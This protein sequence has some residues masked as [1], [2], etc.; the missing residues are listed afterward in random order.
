MMPNSKVTTL[1]ACLAFGSICVYNAQC[2]FKIPLVLHG[3]YLIRRHLHP[4]L[5]PSNRKHRKGYTNETVVN[6]CQINHQTD[7]ITTR[8]TFYPF[9]LIQY[10]LFWKH[11]NASTLLHIPTHDLPSITIAAGYQYRILSA[12][13][14]PC[15]AE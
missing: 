13:T 8:S 14:H 15:L 7:Q 9:L 11:D 10:E 1:L 3:I 2:K 4:W 12:L 6:W 5:N